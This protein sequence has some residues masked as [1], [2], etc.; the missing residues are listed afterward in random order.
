MA[1][2]TSSPT[3]SATAKDRELVIKRVF[4]AP[5]ELVFKA[6]TDPEMLKQW[7]AP[8]GF[9]IPVAEGELK[10]GGKWRSMMRKPDGTELWLGGVYREI[11]PPERLVFTHAWDDKNGKP[12]H[13]TVVTVTLVERNGKTEMTFKQ[14]IFDSVESRDGHKGGWTECFDRLEALISTERASIA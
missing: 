4:D 9:T 7:S 5:R 6:W 2:T 1:A 3:D 13:E 14:G 12:G 11:I 8:Q 10:P